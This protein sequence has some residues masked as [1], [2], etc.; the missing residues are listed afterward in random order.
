MS[1]TFCIHLVRN[2][3]I[4]PEQLIGALEEQLAS[5]PQLGQLA[6]QDGLMTLS[7]LFE[8]LN[9][10][11]FEQKQFGE[12]AIEKGF[13]S[14]AQLAGLLLMQSKAEVSLSDVLLSQRAISATQ[15]AEQHDQWKRENR[16]RETIVVGRMRPTMQTAATA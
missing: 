2:G 9:A 10:Q 3:T 13:L 8:V 6:L 14:K 7:Q 15:L 12:I 4:S 5:R 1:L 11:R 16:R